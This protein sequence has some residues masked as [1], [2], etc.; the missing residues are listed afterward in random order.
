M[1]QNL[2]FQY[3]GRPDGLGNRLEEIVFLEAMCEVLDCKAFYIWQNRHKNRSYPILFTT[4]RVSVIEKAKEAV[5]FKLHKDFT[6]KLSKKQILFSAKKIKPNF[7]LNFSN[8]LRPVGV[9]I[10][11]TDRVGK[12]DPYF[13]KDESELKNYLSEVITRINHSSAK[14]VFLCSE[15]DRCKEVF[16]KYLNKDIELLEPIA[17]PNIPSEYID[18]FSLSLCKEI[19]MAS[20]FSTF[21]ILASMIGNI[22]IKSFNYI[23]DKDS[24]SR[25]AALFEYLTLTNINIINEKIIDNLLLSRVKNFIS[26]RVT[27]LI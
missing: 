14:H 22:T 26:K 20:K 27:F 16:S 23:E 10:R 15:S 18:L 9:H 8:N 19:W 25:Y 6:I 3:L 12:S 2:E 11:A 5:P 13:M 24:H 7:K 1:E 17:T 4:E 21:S